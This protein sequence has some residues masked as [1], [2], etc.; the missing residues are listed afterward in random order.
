MV[1][2]VNVPKVA[3]V[4]NA[5]AT[6]AHRD[7]S[8][9]DGVKVHKVKIESPAVG[10]LAEAVMSLGPPADLEKIATVRGQ[11]ARGEYRIDPAAIAQKML[12][13]E[14]SKE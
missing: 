7:A 12:G 5:T 4:A 9:V 8:N 2:P 6:L 3:G 13:V 14:G 11:I 1:D 10:S